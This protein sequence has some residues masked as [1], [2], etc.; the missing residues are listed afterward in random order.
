MEERKLNVA[1]TVFIGIFILF[2]FILSARSE[3]LDENVWLIVRGFNGS[4]VQVVDSEGN[5]VK[6]GIISGN[7]CYFRVP[8]G[9][10]Q[11]FVGEIGKKVDAYQELNIVEFGEIDLFIQPQ[12]LTGIALIITVM[13]V[14]ALL[15]KKG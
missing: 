12:F 7:Y 15:I 3:Y 8:K 4:K 6:T 11:V 9:T 13:V 14:I 2:S 10:Y 5:L 1:V